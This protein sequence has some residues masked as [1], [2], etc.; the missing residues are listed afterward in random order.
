M[1]SPTDKQAFPGSDAARQANRRA[2]LAR[3]LGILA[4]VMAL[5]FLAVFLIQAGLFA[6]FLPRLRRTVAPWGRPSARFSIQ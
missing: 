6:A 3:G 1:S 2:R 5:G 4:A